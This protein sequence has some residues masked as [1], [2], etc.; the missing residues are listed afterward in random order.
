MRA[1]VLPVILCLIFGAT[2]AARTGP[3]M[4]QTKLKP[5]AEASSSDVEATFQGE[6]PPE[7][8]EEFHDAAATIPEEY[9]TEAL[10]AEFKGHPCCSCS[11][12]W[13]SV[14]KK[15]SK[16]FFKA[17]KTCDIIG[18]KETWSVS[19]SGLTFCGHNCDAERKGNK[20][21]WKREVVS[22]GTRKLYP[23]TQ[24]TGCTRVH[25]GAHGCTWVHMVAL[26]GCQQDVALGNG[27]I[28]L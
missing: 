19:Q 14:F 15:L 3:N 28:R 6:D 25:M 21:C 4:G 11:L 16:F 22:G 13:G 18:G 17:H 20:V 9:R 7:E 8:S 12:S 27:L 26:G 23:D 24:D 5:E 1:P 2:D 10:V